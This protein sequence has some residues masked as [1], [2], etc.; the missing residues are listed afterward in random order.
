MV[1]L[2]I[3]ESELP[4]SSIQCDVNIFQL[5]CLSASYVQ[6]FAENKGYPPLTIC[7]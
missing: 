5:I 4:N 3:I 6:I 7:S 2:G 1:A